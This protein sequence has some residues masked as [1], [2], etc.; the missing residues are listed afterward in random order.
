MKAKWKALR[1]KRWA[2]VLAAVLLVVATTLA[3]ASAALTVLLAGHGYYG[4]SPLSLGEYCA[5]YVET[6]FDVIESKI[7]AI[8]SSVVGL[9]LPEALEETFDGFTAGNLVFT[10]RSSV[11]EL[12][13]TGGSATRLLCESERKV[14]RTRFGEERNHSA[15]Y[16]TEE[17]L[18]RQ[19]ALLEEQGH[20][21]VLYSW[22]EETG[23]ASITY[24]PLI[25]YDV[26]YLTGGIDPSF[27]QHDNFYLGYRLLKL[28]APLEAA[29]PVTAVVC[30]LLSVLL[31]VFLCSGA[32]RQAGDDAIR[33]RLPDRLPLGAFLL[34]TALLALIPLRLTQ[35]GGELF[36]QHGAWSIVCFAAAL[37]TA[38]L[39]LLEL[40]LALCRRFKR[41]G[42]WKNTLCVRVLWPLAKLLR[43]GCAALW[44][45]LP[46]Y[47]KSAIVWLALC[48]VEWVAVSNNILWLWA[49]EK[50]L[51]TPL[52]IAA[53][54][55]LRRLQRGAEKIGGGD[56]SYQIDVRHMPHLLRAH[57]EQLNTI[58][59]GLQS[60]V[61]D[62]MRSERM[63][64]ELITNVSHDIKT[65]LTSIINYIDLLKK[66]GLSS[67]KAPEYLEILDRQSARLKK[68][69]EDLVEASK[70]STGSISV[71]LEAMDLNVVLSQAVGEYE[72]R[73]ERAG[74]ET[75]VKRSDTPAMV[76]ADGK[77]LWRVFDNLLGN[78]C[79]YAQP[80]TRVY[81]RTDRS[82]EWQFVELKNISA[83]EL[84][85]APEEL[86]E[87]F[88]RGDASRNTEGSGLGLSIAQSLMELQGGT[89][90]LTV[91]GDLFKATLHLKA[92]Q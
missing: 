10:V 6:S 23:L 82:G 16:Q 26:L 79:K 61:E 92:V 67:A 19:I 42:W 41:R 1:K 70:A 68:L 69:T 36:T 86:M 43:R 74:L 78:I 57:G 39:L 55:F 20:V 76:Q 51:L 40:L 48:A 80:H 34:L 46:L 33:E 49:A 12:L 75:I 37:L 22:N 66:E 18:D 30:L 14:E 35:L 53:V 27:P 85:I 4:G 5:G 73:L 84:D 24:R 58:G 31:A 62:R 81:L 25:V 54:I 89:L 13:Y 50:L 77:L 91:D 52:L 17:Q 29:L 90:Q 64:A 32:G 88:V 59:D 63:K 83:Q 7:D 72:G 38:E 56:L 11:G 3:L 2:K 9:S 60:A 47:W 8:D 45:N 21:I 28:A 87:R 71:L 65:P 44:R 15:R